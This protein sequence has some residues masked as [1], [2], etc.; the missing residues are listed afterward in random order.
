[1]CT[2]PYNEL[3]IDH[4]HTLLQNNGKY[5]SWL[6]LSAIYNKCTARSGL[7][8]LPKLKLE[9]IRLN[10]Y[11]RMRVYLAVQVK[12]FTHYTQNYFHSI[13]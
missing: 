6:H 5:I 2:L 8:L 9:H 7:S 1:M 4:H 12:R 13:L 3:C 11:S 10:S